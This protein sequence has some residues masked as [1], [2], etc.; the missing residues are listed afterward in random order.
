MAA[1]KSHDRCDASV[2]A[3]AASYAETDLCFYHDVDDQTTEQ[4]T[5]FRLKAVGGLLAPLQAPLKPGS[6]LRVPPAGIEALY[7]TFVMVTLLPFWVKVPFQSWVMVCPLGNEKVRFQ[8][9]IAL[10]PVF[11]IVKAVPK[12]VFHWVV[13]A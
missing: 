12:P 6:E 3:Q 13:M 7:E 2:V 4:A 10:E 5:P 1:Q 9:F 8:P 11:V